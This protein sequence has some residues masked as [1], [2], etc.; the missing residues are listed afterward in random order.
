MLIPVCK[1]RGRS[2]RKRGVPTRSPETTR[3]TC[4]R[5]DTRLAHGLYRQKLSLAQHIRIP[6]SSGNT[7]KAKR[8]WSSDHLQT[9]GCAVGSQQDNRIRQI[10]RTTDSPVRRKALDQVRLEG[11]SVV[12]IHSD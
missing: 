8:K 6:A 9:L 2:C 11:T 4:S 7:K 1:Y 3:H 12:E 5:L 10:R